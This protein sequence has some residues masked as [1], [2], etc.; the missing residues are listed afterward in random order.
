N[1]TITA[2]EGSTAGNSGTFG[3][4]GDDTVVVTA[5]IGTVTQNDVAGTWSWSWDTS[6]GPDDSQTVT[7]TATDSDG[8]ASTTTFALTVTNEAP[9]LADATFQL[10]ENSVN[11]TPVG[12][13]TATD[14]GDDTITYSI[15]GGTGETAFGIDPLTG[16]ITVV[17]QSQLD[18]ETTASFTL[19]IAAADDDNDVDSATVLINLQN[20]ATISGVVYVDTDQDGHFD[21]DEMGID[22]VVVELLNTAGDVLFSTVTEDGGLYFFEDMDAGTYRIRESQPSGVT[23]GPEQLGSVGGSVIADDLME[24]TVSDTDASDYNFAEYGQQLTSG[25]TAGI[26]FWQNKHG[27]ELIEAGGTALADWLGDNFGNIFGTEFVG[28]SGADVASFYK[29]QLFKQKGKKSAGPAKVDAQFMAVAFA[30]FFTSQNLAGTV[31]TGYGF[32]VSDTGIGTRIVNV[33]NSGAAFGVDDDTDLTIMQLLLATNQ[34]T[35][36]PDNYTGFASIYDQ[37]GD[38]VI[39]SYEAFLRTL[40]NSVYGAI[41]D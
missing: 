32:H 21:A 24:L 37:N 10:L 31:A 27:Q 40:A 1:A 22:D 19:E 41:N 25:D 34:L 4:V 6:D 33:G 35:D 36:I 29:N 20:Q 9:V 2:A 39:D 14:V 12:T 17:D 13:V 8:A 7:I 15:V 30:T 5:S 23:D 26:G 16:D 18:F 38:G 3:D 11:G 28:A